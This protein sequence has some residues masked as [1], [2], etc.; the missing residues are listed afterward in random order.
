MYEDLY[1]I[2]LEKNVDIVK[3]SF[4][5]KYDTPI[6]K[7]IKEINWNKNYNLP[8]DI[9]NIKDCPLFLYFHPSIWTCIYKREFLIKNNIKFVEALSAAWTDNPFQVQTMVL[10]D[11]I[12]YTDKPYYY[13]RK[14][15]DEESLALKDIKIPLERSKE[16]HH[17]LEEYNVD[18]VDILS[19]IYKRELVYIDLILRRAS[20]INRK[21]AYNISRQLLNL[22]SPDIIYNNK[23]FSKKECKKYKQ[24]I[25]HIDQRYFYLK[26]KIFEGYFWDNFIA[27]FVLV[28]NR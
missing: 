14:Q 1:N 16:I 21:D 11:K 20:F 24:L 18:N 22:M 6:N 8:Q 23:Y 10:A 25:K 12:F 5:E 9:F 3:S 4:Y 19:C 28:K 13:W 26:Y 15:F 27:K 7:S 17:W 2:A